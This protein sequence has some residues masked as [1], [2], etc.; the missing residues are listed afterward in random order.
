MT[1]SRGSPSRRQR[2]RCV[3]PDGA[4]HKFVLTVGRVEAPEHH[5]ADCHQEVPA[6]AGPFIAGGYHYYASVVADALRDIARGSTYVA[7]SVDARLALQK[8]GAFRAHL[9]G[10]VFRAVEPD[11]NGTLAADWVEVF[12]DVVAPAAEEWPEIVLLDSTDFW[13]R[14][15]GRKVP[16]FAVLFAYGYDLLWGPMLQQEPWLKPQINYT[17]GRLLRAVI[18]PVETTQAW[19][20]FLTSWQGR[21]TVV[22]ADGASRLRKAVRAAWPASKSEASPE[23]VRCV[24]HMRENLRRNARR[25]LER[26][27][28]YNKQHQTGA[29]WHNPETHTLITN[30]A[31]AFTGPRQW[32]G[33]RADAFAV[34]GRHPAFS[35]ANP[36]GTLKWLRSHDTLVLAQLARRGRRVGP[37]SI[38][39][40]EAHILNFRTVLQRRAQSIRNPL[41]TN[42]LLRLL[43]EGANNAADRRVWG[44]RIYRHLSHNEGHPATVQRVIN[45]AHL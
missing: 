28:G 18:V 34:F 11:R 37:S 45:G 13:R 17:N 20:D 19:Y 27:N 42:L 44:E 29:P 32:T 24:W 39:P 36:S 22:V 6:N 2:Y 31:S 26:M 9:N 33:Y 30:A 25:D 16:A 40:L 21:P 10:E 43:V 23:F 4:Q 3:S 35:D 5:C 7:S 38:G 15:G 12:T 14:G 1:A 8:A 41:R